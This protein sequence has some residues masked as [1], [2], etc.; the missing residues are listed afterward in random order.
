MSTLAGCIAGEPDT[1]VETSGPVPDAGQ[2]PWTS[3]V[4]HGEGLCSLNRTSATSAGVQC[5]EDT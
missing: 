3:K 2:G 1:E 5:Q 4:S